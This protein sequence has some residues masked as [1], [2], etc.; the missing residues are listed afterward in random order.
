M[1]SALRLALSYCMAPA[2]ALAASLLVAIAGCSAGNTSNFG[3]DDASG[4]SGNSGN[5]QP[6]GGSGGIIFDG[7]AS[8]G[9]SEPGCA[10]TTK[11]VYVIDDSNHF[12]RFNPA[13]ASPAAFEQVSTLGCAT[14]GSPNSMA[15]SREGNAYV[16]FG[17]SDDYGDFFCDGVFPVDVDSGACSGQTPFQCGQAGFEKFGMGYSTDSADST[18]ERLFIGSS[19]DDQFGTLDPATGAAQFIGSLPNQGPEFTGNAN[20]ELWGFFPYDSPPTAR[21]LNKATGGADQ[22]LA[23]P[24]LPDMTYGDSAAW[25]FAYWGGSFYIFYMVSPYDSSTVVYKL[26]YDGTVSTFIADTGLVIV[27]AG[28]STCAPITPPN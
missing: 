20:G 14:S 1:S 16:L 15:V 25:A 19:I 23:L 18:A 28:V 22:T 12:Y 7:G 3:D 8:S 17:S 9:G 5:H 21:R 6:S 4:G 11:L 10:E 27:G 13:I 2:P 26:E 24:S